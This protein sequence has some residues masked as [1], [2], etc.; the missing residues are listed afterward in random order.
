MGTVT[1]LRTTTEA[2]DAGVAAPRYSC[3]L[4]GAYMATL[5]S[6]GTVPILFTDV[7]CDFSQTLGTSLN[8]A[9]SRRDIHTVSS[10]PTEKQEGPGGKEMLRNLI[11]SSLRPAQGDLVAV[12]SGCV[13]SEIAVEVG[14]VV[15]EFQPQAPIIHVEAAGFLG[16]SYVGYE[17]FFDAV[18]DQLL[19]A[20]PVKRRRVNLLG[21]VPYQHVFWKGNLQVLKN[22][23]ENIGLSVNMVFTEHGGT[24]ALRQIPAAE[25]NLVFSSWSGIPAARKLEQKFGTPFVVIAAVPVGPEDTSALLRF[26][27]RRLKLRRKA[28]EL[29]IGDQELRAYRFKNHPPDLGQPPPAGL[30]VGIVADT[31]TAIGLTRYGSNEM[32]WIPEVVIITDDPPGEYREDI[33][34]SL[35]QGLRCPVPPAVHFQVDTSKVRLLLKGHSPELILASSLEKQLTGHELQADQVSV[36]FPVHDRLIVDRTYAGYR[37][38]L[39]LMEDVAYGNGG[40]S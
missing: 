20:L 31:G 7:N 16:N 38:G 21:V 40:H 29:Y 3:A 35:T 30:R 18:I 24:E 4:G 32:G 9:G 27:A 37:G 17:Q 15:R 39:A 6:Y 36:A 26:L 2:E 34:R 19:T 11:T 28:V 25:L 10:D 1:K 12:V 14:A 13:P 23:L 8:G 33:V 22:L 5:A